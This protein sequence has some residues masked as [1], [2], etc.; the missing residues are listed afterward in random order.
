MLLFMFG[1][2]GVFALLPILL[3]DLFQMLGL[4]IAGDRVSDAIPQADKDDIIAKGWETVIWCLALVPFVIAITYAALY[5]GYYVAITALRSLR[6]HYLS[7]FIHQEMGF[8][9]NAKQGDTLARMTADLTTVQAFLK[10]LYGKFQARPFE[11]LGLMVGLFFIEWRLALV[12]LV[13]FLP[14]LAVLGAMFRRNRKRAK[15]AR[16]A[17]IDTFVTFEQIAAGFRVI[18]SLGTKTKKL[19][20]SAIAITIGAAKN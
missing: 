10:N 8:H 14:I 5:S 16:G 13:I 12:V 7:A 19:N 1:M 15:A 11:I 9:T 20:V 3:A 18:K 6:A 4:T 17:L 2:S